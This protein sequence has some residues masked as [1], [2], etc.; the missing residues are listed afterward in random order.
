MYKVFL[1]DTSVFFG[2]RFVRLPEEEVEMGSKNEEVGEEGK[3][4]FL[5]HVKI[6]M[7]WIIHINNSHYVM[8][9]KVQKWDRIFQLFYC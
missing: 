5:L 6:T 2:R 9:L 8:V 3:L 7:F 4:S 1:M